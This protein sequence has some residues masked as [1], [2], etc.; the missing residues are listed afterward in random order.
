MQAAWRETDIEQ[1]RVADLMAMLPVEDGTALDIGARDGFISTRLANRG[2]AVTAL[3]L[4]KPDIA[5]PRIACVKGDASALEFIDNCFDLVFCAEVLEHIPSAVL[6]TACLE[7]ARVSRRYVLIGVPYEQDLRLDR[8]TCLGCG[9][10]NPPWGHV[11]RF[12]EARLRRLFPGY[13]M[14]KSSF[15]G[16]SSAATNFLSWRL[17]EAAG[18]PYGT[19]LQDEPCIHCGAALS[20][21]DGRTLVSRC[22]AKVAVLACKAQAPFVAARPK[23]MHVLFEKRTG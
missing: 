17:M 12:D 10:T 21:P 5:D 7:L 6:E 3:D 18:N 1:A 9:K 16:A 22:L 15:V 23:W 2:M 11:N 4:E 8:S 13:R 19:Y 14:L 20:A